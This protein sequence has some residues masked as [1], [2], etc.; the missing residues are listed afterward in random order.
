MVVSSTSVL[1]YLPLDGP[2]GFNE[3]DVEDGYDSPLSLNICTPPISSGELTVE[4][5]PQ[6]VMMEPTTGANIP[7]HETLRA[8]EKVPCPEPH[9]MG[10]DGKGLFIRSILVPPRPFF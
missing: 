10:M 1:P 7:E 9:L 8:A 3:M 2:L 4:E 6:N 5:T